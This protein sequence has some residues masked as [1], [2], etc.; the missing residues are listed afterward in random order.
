[1]LTRDKKYDFLPM[2]RHAYSRPIRDIR[3]PLNG[4]YISK[5]KIWDFGELLGIPP[6]KAET[7]CLGPIGDYVPSLFSLLFSSLLFG[8]DSC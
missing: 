8:A 1:M 4:G 6:P 2:L 7:L 5:P 3:P